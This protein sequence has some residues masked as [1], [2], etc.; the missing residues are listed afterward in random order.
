MLHWSAGLTPEQLEL[1]QT[2]LASDFFGTYDTIEA[3]KEDNKKVRKRCVSCGK[4]MSKDT[5]YAEVDNA[6]VHIV[7]KCLAKALSIKV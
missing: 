6:L 7:E 3:L 2:A 5:A 1:L 4:F